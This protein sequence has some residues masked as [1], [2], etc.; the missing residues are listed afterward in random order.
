MLSM[1]RDV[2]RG[3]DMITPAIYTLTGVRA[4]LAVVQCLLQLVD[5]FTKSLILALRDKE[6]VDILLSNRG[7]RFFQVIHIRPEE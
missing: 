5:F 6:R 4:I 3:T 2:D 7:E 1:D